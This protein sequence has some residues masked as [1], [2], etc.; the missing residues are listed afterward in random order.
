MTT[1][2]LQPS[3]CRYCGTGTHLHYV[4]TE[5]RAGAVLRTVVQGHIAAG[6]VAV[7]LA[8][9]VR[10][11][12]QPNGMQALCEYSQYLQLLCPAHATAGQSRIAQ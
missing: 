10:L 9:E 2:L 5:G 1:C 11:L 8:G 12:L 7:V 6:N 3:R 4:A